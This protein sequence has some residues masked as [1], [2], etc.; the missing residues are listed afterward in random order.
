MK[1]GRKAKVS[2]TLGRDLL[3]AIDRRVRGGTTRS[4]VIEEWLRLSALAVARR[5]LDAATAAYYEGRTAEQRAE[6]ESL[7]AFSARAFDERD[8]D[9]KPRTRRPRAR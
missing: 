5:D 3:A 8:L 4:Q 7:A 2:V 9:R 6:D 1:P